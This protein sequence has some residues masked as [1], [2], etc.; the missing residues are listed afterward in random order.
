MEKAL[1]SHSLAGYMVITLAIPISFKISLLKWRFFSLSI[2]TNV[3]TDQASTVEME[4]L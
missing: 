4:N 2:V 3:L 1:R